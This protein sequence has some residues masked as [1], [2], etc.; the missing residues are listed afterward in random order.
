MRTYDPLKI[1]CVFA[2]ILIKG[3]A[4][5]TFLQAE[6]DEDAFSLV[7]G[8]G[9]EGT[10]VRNRNRAGKVTFTLKASDPTNDAL[11]AVQKADELLGTG[12]APLLVKDLG[13]TTLISSANSFIAKPPAVEF[14][15]ELGT[16]EWVI[17]CEALDIQAGGNA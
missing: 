15:K 6:R 11:T 4:D 3:Y 1:V 16:R 10:R 5:G 2:G 12:V 8:A 9:G 14:G 17:V 13:G 7:I